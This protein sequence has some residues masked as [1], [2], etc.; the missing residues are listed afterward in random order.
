MQLAHRRSLHRADRHGVLRV[1]NGHGQIAV[2]HLAGD[3]EIHLSIGDLRGQRL[4]VAKLCRAGFRFPKRAILDRAADIE[5]LPLGHDALVREFAELDQC[6]S[7][8][9][10]PW[11]TPAAKRVQ[12]GLGKDRPAAHSD[13]DQARG[14]E[15]APARR[16]WTDGLF[17]IKL[18]GFT[19]HLTDRRAIKGGRENSRPFFLISQL[20]DAEQAVAQPA[21]TPLHQASERA[22]VALIE[23]PAGRPPNHRPH[24]DADTAGQQ[25]QPKPARAVPQAVGKKQNQIGA[26][27]PGGREAHRHGGFHLPKTPL[28]HGELLSQLVGKIVSGKFF[29]RV[30]VGC[31][32]R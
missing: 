17:E 29:L 15:R 13:E 22:R 2:L 30:H 24:G 5:R 28:H 16:L 18:E 32:R 26:E 14:D 19:G 31:G 12:A 4:V 10:R 3:G 7:R 1:A 20:D 8:D 9:I 11:Q 6:V 23:H 27:Q 25:P 21:L